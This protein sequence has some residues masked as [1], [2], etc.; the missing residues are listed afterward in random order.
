MGR[1]AAGA[2][3]MS[4]LASQIRPSE[5]F[6]RDE[7]TRDALHSL[8]VNASYEIDGAVASLSNSDDKGLRYHAERVFEHLRLAHAQLKT[9]GGAV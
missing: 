8:F 7:I 3:P 6:E 2:L 9:L 4:A 1:T 5:I